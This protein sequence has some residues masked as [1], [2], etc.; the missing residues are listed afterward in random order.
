MQLENYYGRLV[1]GDMKDTH[2]DEIQQFKAIE[3]NVCFR[4]GTTTLDLWQ[5][6]HNERY[7]WACAQLGRLSEHNRLFTIAEPHTF[8]SDQTTLRWT[9]Q[10]SSVQ[11]RISQ[12]LIKSYRFKQDHLIYAVTGAGKTEM[13]YPLLEYVISC[14]H[15]V[16]Y[17]APRIDVVIEIAQRVR[18]DF[19]IDAVLLYGNSPE[20]YRYTQMVFAT[21]HQLLNFYQAFDLIIVDEVDAFPYAGNDLLKNAVEQA[22]LPTGRIVYLSATPMRQMLQACRRGQLGLSMMPRRYHGYPLPEI[23]VLI[24]EN[25]RDHC[26]Y[27]LKKLLAQYAITKKR[28]LIFVP[29]IADIPDVLKWVVCHVEAASVFAADD[30]RAEKVQTMRENKI[31]GLITTTI[32]ERGVTFPNLDVI[33]LGADEASYSEAALIQMAGRCGR[34]KEF[35]TGLV[36]CIVTEKTQKVRRAAREIRRLNRMRS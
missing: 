4:C 29:E 19:V 12:E 31:Q 11:E 7:C 36:L 23:K 21:T 5:I 34:S 3:E 27:R 2:P 1:V 10:L 35:P 25:W 18:R 24:A 26:P 15:R 32:L 13:L 9:G 17:V 16:A 8:D 20:E 28:F 33:I 6:D 30:R 22:R 14:K